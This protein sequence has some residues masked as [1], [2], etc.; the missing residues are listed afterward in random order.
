MNIGVGVTGAS[1]AI[2]ALRL[3]EIAGG[4][5]GVT[6]H[7]IFSTIGKKIFEIE[8]EKP[9]ETLKSYGAVIH[10]NTDIF[11]PYA[12]GSNTFDAMAVLPCSMN[13]LAHIAAGAADTLITRAAD[14]MLKERRKLL[15]VIRETPLSLTHIRNMESVT[16]SGGILL[17]A[18]PSFYMEPETIIDL[19]D[20]VIF[21]ITDQLGI[22]VDHP[23]YEGGL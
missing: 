18:S 11:L 10:E 15:L 20:S 4:I 9:V 1:G 21:R 7:Y 2:Y 14:V 17:P 12:S 13:T 8:L 5:D 22:P 19:V 3:A 23:R 16:L 6:L